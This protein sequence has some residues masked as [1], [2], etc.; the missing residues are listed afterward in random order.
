MNSNQQR[1]FACYTWLPFFKKYLITVGE[2]TVSFVFFYYACKLSFLPMN[3]EIPFELI[4]KFFC[5]NCSPSE[6]ES[7]LQWY[8]PY[9]KDE[10]CISTFQKMNRIS[11]NRLCI[12]KFSNQ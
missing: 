9:H 7:I 12:P 4:Q 6:I 3:V 10:D 1:K 2:S 5:G 8:D 11:W